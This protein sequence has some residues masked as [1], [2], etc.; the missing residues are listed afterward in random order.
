MRF[1]FI[2]E[3]AMKRFTGL[4]I[5]FFALLLVLP[6]GAQTRLGFTAGLN[7]A[8]SGS[9]EL[10]D[11]IAADAGADTELSSR[12]GFAVGGVLQLMLS[13][14]VA[15][16][17]QPMYLQK[18]TKI[19]IDAFDFDDTVTLSYIEVPVMAKFMLGA[20]QTRPYVMGGPTLGLK[21]GASADELDVDSDDFNGFDFGVA[22]GGGV[23]FPAG[24]NSF[25]VEGRFA[26]GLSNILKEDTFGDL[27]AKNKGIMINAGMTFPMGGQ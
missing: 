27:S 23:S 13:E 25:F 1:F 2:K 3:D 17:F 24:N 6:V 20:S 4:L 7:L 14:N 26:F 8:N 21:V 19:K 5:V 15:L 22:F 11:A 10:A 9:D 12:L 18:G 16:Q